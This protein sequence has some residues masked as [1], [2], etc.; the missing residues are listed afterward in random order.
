MDYYTNDEPLLLKEYGRNVQ[1]LVKFIATIEDK[2]KRTRAAHTLVNLMKQLNPSVKENSESTQQ[3]IW[4]HLYIMSNFELDI[5]GPFPKPDETILDKKPEPL[6]YK[7]KELKHKHYGRNIELLIDLAANTEDPDERENAIMYIGRLMKTFYT[8]WNRENIG[9]DVIINHLYEMSK[10]KIDMRD[11]L[12]S[13]KVV[14][15]ISIPRDKDLNNS[16]GKSNNPRRRS[17]KPTNKRKD[18][19]NK[20]RS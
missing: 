8:S 18:N 3:R 15:E 9:D 5:D 19:N 4:D 6:T 7:D 16:K 14:F 17:S 2:E 20:R 12:K 13:D 10:G 11:Q 1:R